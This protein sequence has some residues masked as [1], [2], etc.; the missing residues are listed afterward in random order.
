MRPTEAF[1]T[2]VKK[3]GPEAVPEELTLSQCYPNPFNPET[4]IRFTVAR[5][6]TAT[7]RVYNLLGQLISEIFRGEVSP[8]KE[9]HTRFRADGSSSGTYFYTVSSGG[10]TIT[11]RMVLQR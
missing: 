5:E 11:K 7:V 10:S 1:P 9:Y 2:S 4:V 8:G 3:N 6:G